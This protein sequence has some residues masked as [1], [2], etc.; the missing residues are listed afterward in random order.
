VAESGVAR[1]G[2]PNRGKWRTPKCGRGP[3]LIFA[4]KLRARSV[5][6]GQFFRLAIKFPLRS[7]SSV[8]VLPSIGQR[9]MEFVGSEAD[10]RVYDISSSEVMK[11]GGM[12][13]TSAQTDG[14]TDGHAKRGGAVT[15]NERQTPL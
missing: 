1:S 13:W 12:R 5:A 11:A 7:Q 2:K 15:D 10:D 9:Q 8:G 3:T 14:G 6:K 4:V